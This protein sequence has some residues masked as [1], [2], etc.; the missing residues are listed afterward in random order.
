MSEQDYFRNALSDF[1]YEAASGAA[2]RHLT[3][4][5]YTVK[6]ICENLT[7]PTPYARVQ[8]TVWRQLLDT[9]VVL[10]AKPGEERQTGKPQYELE[11][12]RYGRASFRLVAA[13]VKEK[14]AIFWKQRRYDR[15]ADGRL[16]DFLDRK[17]SADGI[18]NAYASCDFGLWEKREQERFASAMQALN[19]RQREYVTGLAWEEKTCYHRLDRRMQ[20]ILVRLY[21]AGLYTGE[22]FFIKSKERVELPVRPFS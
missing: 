10:L 6:Q 1:T 16:A 18:E 8:K 3:D 14:D 20:E 2:V 17:C 9:G 7:Y 22:I 21:A 4:L 5:G 13:P 12:D 19:E 11:H 15:E